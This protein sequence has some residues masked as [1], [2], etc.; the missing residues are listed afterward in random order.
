MFSGNIP[1][2]GSAVEALSKIY[3]TMTTDGFDVERVGQS[4]IVTVSGLKDLL[5]QT[6]IGKIYWSKLVLEPG[7]GEIRYSFVY[8]VQA[9]LL[10]HLMVT[11]FFFVTLKEHYPPSELNLW[12][13][14]LAMNVVAAVITL[15]SANHSKTKIL[16]KLRKKI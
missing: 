14:I 3:L 7:E 2:E 5:F 1:V 9:Q 6:Q 16:Q 4:L 11:A 13:Y 10:F 8:R 12:V 15:V